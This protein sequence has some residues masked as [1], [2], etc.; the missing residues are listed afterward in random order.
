MIYKNN[1]QLLITFNIYSSFNIEASIKS[2]FSP[3]DRF[4]VEDGGIEGGGLLLS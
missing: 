3:S 2:F 1:I 4:D